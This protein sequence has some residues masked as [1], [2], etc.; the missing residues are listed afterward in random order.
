[1]QTPDLRITYLTVAEIGY[2]VVGCAAVEYA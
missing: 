2:E 1:M